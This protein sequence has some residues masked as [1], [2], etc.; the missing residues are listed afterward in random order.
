[1]MPILPQFAIYLRGGQYNQRQKFKKILQGASEGAGAG[2][3][4]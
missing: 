1:M 3:I 2:W 4:H